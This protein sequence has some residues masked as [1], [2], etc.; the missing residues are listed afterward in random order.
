MMRESDVYFV[1][2]TY[3]LRDVGEA[4]EQYDEHFWRNGHSPTIVVFDD[5][6]L[7]AQEKYYPSLEQTR[8]HSELFYVGPK[9]KEQFIGY[10]S[11]RLRDSGSTAWSRTCSGRATGGTATIPYVHA[12]RADDLAPTTTCGPMP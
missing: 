3:R 1:I 11:R 8:T 12:G 9:E 6:S 5:S 10:L 4:V 2:P 7:A